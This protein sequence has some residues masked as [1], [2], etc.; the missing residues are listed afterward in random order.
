M[1]SVQRRTEDASKRLERE[2]EPFRID[3]RPDRRRVF[4]VPCGEL[5]MATVGQLAAEIDEL[6]GRGFDTVVLDLRAISFLDSSGLHL[7]LQQA[8]RPDAQVS[9]I[10]G[11]PAVQRAIEL[12][13]VRDLLRFEEAA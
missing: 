13:G 1:T 2:L 4:V 3:I 11:A 5:D 10:D 8:A 12:A 7:L 6:V 9:L